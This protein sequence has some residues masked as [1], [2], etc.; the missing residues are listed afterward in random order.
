[1]GVFKLCFF[2]FLPLVF[3]VRFIGDHE[4]VNIAGFYFVFPV[5]IYNMVYNT[6]NL[7]LFEIH[8]VKCISIN[9]F[10]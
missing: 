10:C 3:P 5:T 4:S 6:V 7:S 8:A 2:L 1:M 9:C